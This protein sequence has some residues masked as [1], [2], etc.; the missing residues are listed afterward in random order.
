[1]N[2]TLL[3]I[4]CDFLLIS[5]LALV[6]FEPSVETDSVDEAALRDEAA[7]EM[8]ELLQLSLEHEN[9]QREAVEGTL[10]QTMARLDEKEDALSQTSRELEMTE[11]TLQET[12]RNLQETN[13][14]LEE[15]EA[16]KRQ[17]D[18]QLEETRGSLELTLAEKAELAETLAQREA[19]ARRLQA[20][21]RAQQE[22]AARKTAELEAARENLASLEAERR[23]MST[24]L[25]I[26][27]TEKQMLEQNLI[28]ARAEVERAR[29]DAERA[30]ERSESLAEGVSEL[31]ASSSE[32]KEQIQKA[33]PLS[34]N[35]IYKRF[36][37]NR[38]FLRF[39]WEERLLLGSSR[40]E[41]ALQVIMVQTGDSVHA[42]FATANTPVADA[43]PPSS[44]GAILTIGDRS[45]AV[46]EM[47]FME[48]ERRIGAIRIPASIAGDSGLLDFALSTD[49]FRFTNAVLVSNDRELY[50]EIPLRVPPGEPGFLEVEDNLFN[51]LFGEFSPGPGDYVFSM[52]GDLVGIMVS[53]KRVRMLDEPDFGNPL[54]L[55]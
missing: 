43:R 29:I 13:R 45:F 21:L 27:A 15:R 26:R 4:I 6:E 10:E 30:Q 36:E 8:L 22:A 46:K 19:R 25:Q 14:T 7:E 18:E 23:E 48:A 41:T 55:D 37:D 38:I 52:T 54:T 24:Q 12:S 2:K 32:L 11:E 33:Q 31:A 51:R 20:E 47:Q 40:R 3:I 39:E 1:M 16:E 9:A 50:G 44:L 42:V 35:A 28:A 5:I 17:L 34:M 49:P 53:G